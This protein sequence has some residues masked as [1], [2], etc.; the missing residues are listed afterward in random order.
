MSWRPGKRALQQRERDLAYADLLRTMI[1]NESDYTNHRT[2]WL[3]VAEGLMVTGVANL[4]KDYPGPAIGLAIIGIL[5]AASYGHA[6]QNG[7]DTRQYFKR[8]WNERVQARGYDLED[9]LLVHGGYPGNRAISW[10]LPDKFVPRILICAW[11]IFAV[12]VYIC[13]F[14]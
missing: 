3:L 14:K 5:V 8:L 4:L 6:L 12:Y 9:V 2:T 10:L 13:R 11:V 1:K 7:I